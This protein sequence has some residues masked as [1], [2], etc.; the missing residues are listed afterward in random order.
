MSIDFVS[1]VLA[2]VNAWLSSEAEVPDAD[3]NP[4]PTPPPR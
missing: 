4:I 3:G 2:L 1:S